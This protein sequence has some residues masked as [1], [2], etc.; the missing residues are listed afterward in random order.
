[1]R[2]PSFLTAALFTTLCAAPALAG[3]CE[4]S[5]D[6][7]ST[8]V[9][10]ALEAGTFKTLAT[11]LT[12]AGLVDTLQGDGPFTVFAPTDAAFAKL[13]KGTVET[14]LE[15]ENRA[16]LKAILLHHVVSGRV[17]ADQAAKRDHAPTLNGQRAKLQVTEAEITIG[18]AKI[19]KADIDCSNGV[20]H[21][22]DR[23]ILPNLDDL[24]TTAHKAGGFKTLATAIRASGL[25]KALQGDGPFT[26]FAPTDEAFAKLPKQVLES[27]LEPENKSKLAE[28][29]SLHVVAGRLYSDQAL[30]AGGATSLQGSTLSIEMADGVARV[31]GSQLLKTDI[32][33][34]NGVIHVIDT[35]L[36][37][38]ATK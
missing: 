25:L 16:A 33:A 10:T 11:A 7:K 26:V 32:E 18:G 2:A 14:L 34:A 35:V 30:E 22:I 29:L 5:C 6:A 4:S 9:E 38:R 19:V 8:I 20:I 23:V 36:L 24:L 31:W 27:L 1:M 28:I 37:P 17:M 13:P 15:P 3:D 12:Q 21:V